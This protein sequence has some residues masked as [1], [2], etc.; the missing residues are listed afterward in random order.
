MPPRPHP[1]RSMRRRKMLRRRGRRQTEPEEVAKL[2]I[3]T[4][5]ADL[6]AVHPR[7]AGIRRGAESRRDRA[8]GGR[9]RHGA[10]RRRGKVRQCWRAWRAWPAPPAPRAPKRA[11]ARYVR[12]RWIPPR[13]VSPK[14]S[15]RRSSG[16]TRPGRARTTA[17]LLAELAAGRVQ[18]VARHL[19]AGCAE[20]R[21]PE[22]SARR[23]P[24][25][26]L[27]RPKDGRRARVG[28]AGRSRRCRDAVS[29]R[30]CSTRTRAKASGF[31]SGRTA[32]APRRPS[33]ACSSRP[34]PC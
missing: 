17:R 5:A 15:P 2:G 4:T 20:R 14:P 3:V 25:C 12:R 26:R 10:G 19:S 7:K 29:S 16:S 24:R 13:C 28:C 31:W 32:M 6:R 11:R 1:T 27:P 34:P 22:Q 18:T 23:A 33:P 9:R 8:G 21:R 30:C